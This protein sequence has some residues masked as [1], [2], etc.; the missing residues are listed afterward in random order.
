[1]TALVSGGLGGSKK[2]HFKTNSSTG[3]R[4]KRDR[5]SKRAHSKRSMFGKAA[6]S[7]GMQ[8]PSVHMERFF[9]NDV[10]LHLA[11]KLGPRGCIQVL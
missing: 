4:L 3:P 9:A 1:M 6:L 2:A 5:E 11:Y 8:K 10:M 7:Y